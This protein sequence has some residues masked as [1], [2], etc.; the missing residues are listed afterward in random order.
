M[1]LGLGNNLWAGGDNAITYG[2]NFFL[3]GSTVTR[4][5]DLT[6]SVVGPKYT[7]EALRRELAEAFLRQEKS[8]G[9]AP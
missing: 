3:P 8:P 7:G 4:I 9:A 2:M 1:T 6:R 5:I